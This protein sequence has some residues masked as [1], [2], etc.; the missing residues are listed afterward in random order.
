MSKHFPITN[1]FLQFCSTQYV[2]KKVSCFGH[3]QQSCKE[4]VMSILIGMW[5]LFEEDRRD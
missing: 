2:A 1:A 4:V 3:E 5:V